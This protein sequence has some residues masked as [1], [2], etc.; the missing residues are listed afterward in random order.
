MTNQ[1][2]N[3]FSI[4]FIISL[5]PDSLK[6][7]RSPFYFS[8]FAND[9][10]PRYIFARKEIICFT[11]SIKINRKSVAELFNEFFNN[12]LFF[13]ARDAE[14]SKIVI[15]NLIINIFCRRGSSALQGGHHV[16]QKFINTTFPF[17]T[18]DENELP[19]SDVVLNAGITSPT[20]MIVVVA[21]SSC[22][23]KIEQ[24]KNSITISVSLDFIVSP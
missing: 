13:T 12:I 3:S 10:I 14:H 6:T 2:F 21:R 18:S 9:K 17:N 24:K 8:I 23:D 22:A 16:A 4:S 1:F 15:F 5:N 20:F 11:L 19:E 7:G